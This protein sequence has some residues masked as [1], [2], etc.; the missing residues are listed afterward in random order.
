[1]KRLILFVVCVLLCIGLI[2]TLNSGQYIGLTGVL[3]KLQLIDFSFSD[4][5]QLAIDMFDSFQ[6]IGESDNI[7]QAVETAI[8][9]LF[10]LVRIPF[11]AVREFL[12]LLTNIFDLLFT[13]VGVF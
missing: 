5:V 2:A 11:V 6:D 8:E 13:L 10:D 1:M 12:F 7:F 4:T 3:D 9:G